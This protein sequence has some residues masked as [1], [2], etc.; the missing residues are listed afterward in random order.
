VPRILAVPNNV[1]GDSNSHPRFNL[2]AFV[3]LTSI[4]P[5]ASSFQLLKHNSGRVGRNCGEYEFAVKQSDQVVGYFNVLARG[6][7]EGTLGFLDCAQG[8]RKAASRA[9]RRTECPGA[10][11]NNRERRPPAA[12]ANDR[13]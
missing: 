10:R 5:D 8:H 4:E 6:F 9:Q 1:C 13:Y 3:A 2:D 7:L 11:C 12:C